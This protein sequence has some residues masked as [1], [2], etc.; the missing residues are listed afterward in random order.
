MNT[1]NCY[2]RSTEE[3]L[4]INEKLLKEF[5]LTFTDRTKDLDLIQIIA[6]FLLLLVVNTAM[7]SVL[8]YTCHKHQLDTCFSIRK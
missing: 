8:P 2:S 4:S 6:Q 5:I 7:S 1:R 3:I